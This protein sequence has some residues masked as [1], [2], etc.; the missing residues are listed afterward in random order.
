MIQRIIALLKAVL[1]PFIEQPKSQ[2][3]DFRKGSVR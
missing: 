2:L 1:T 3:I